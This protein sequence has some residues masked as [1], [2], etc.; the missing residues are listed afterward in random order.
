MESSLEQRYAIKFYSKL[1]K[2][3]GDTLKMFVEASGE[4]EGRRTPLRAPVNHVRSISYTLN[5]PKTI[6]HE[7][8][9][10]KM[11][12]RKVCKQLVAKV[13]TDV[14]NLIFLN[15]VI[16]SNETSLKGTRF[17]TIEA[18]QRAATRTRDRLPGPIGMAALYRDK[19]PVSGTSLGILVGGWSTVQVRSYGHFLHPGRSHQAA[20]RVV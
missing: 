15:N 13:L 8:V 9:T 4:K 5:I 16:T 3:L 12:T 10:E 6:V 17:G 19:Y 2:S 11:N 14:R 20:V 1:N 18:I 7:L